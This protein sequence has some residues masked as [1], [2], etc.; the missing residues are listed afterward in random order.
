MTAANLNLEDIAYVNL[1]PY[2]TRSGAKYSDLIAQKALDEYIIPLVGGAE[3]K[4][5]HRTWK[6]RPFEE[7]LTK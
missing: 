5:R 3:A 2:R 4:D 7:L 1:L 6:R